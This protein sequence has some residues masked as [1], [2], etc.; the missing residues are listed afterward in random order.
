MLNETLSGV[1]PFAARVASVTDGVVFNHSAVPMRS[2]GMGGQCFLTGKGLATSVTCPCFRGCGLLERQEPSAIDK[3]Q[4]KPFLPYVVFCN[5]SVK[6]PACGCGCSQ[7]AF[8]AGVHRNPRNPV[9]NG[10]RVLRPKAMRIKLG[11]PLARFET[12]VKP[13][14]LSTKG[15]RHAGPQHLGAILEQPVWMTQYMD[16]YLNG[17]LVPRF[18]KDGLNLQV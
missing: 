10:F 14:V 3:V 7:S 11:E 1:I 4:V 8:P 13:G 17:M 15:N 6:S 16:A 12:C 9:T 2:A 5:G 18:I